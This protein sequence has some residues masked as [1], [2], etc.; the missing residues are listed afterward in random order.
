LKE[1]EATE[2]AGA[3][4]TCLLAL[5]CPPS[6]EDWNINGLFLLG[7]PGKMALIF[8]ERHTECSGGNY[9]NGSDFSLNLKLKR[10]R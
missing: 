10:L 1:K 2:D 8:I 6:S 3:L 9:Q 5:V 7:D 4:S